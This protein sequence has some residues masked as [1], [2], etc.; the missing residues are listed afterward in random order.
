MSDHK[1]ELF[2]AATSGDLDAVRCL[3]NPDSALNI[4]ATNAADESLLVDVIRA[5]KP[6][7]AHHL[8]DI[9]AAD[10]LAVSRFFRSRRGDGYTLWRRQPILVACGESLCDAVTGLVGDAMRLPRVGCEQ[11]RGLVVLLKPD[12]SNV[13]DGGCL[14]LSACSPA[15]KRSIA[16]IIEMIY[17]ANGGGVLDFRQSKD[18]NLLALSAHHRMP[19]LF[20]RIQPHFGDPI[21][22]D[23][24]MPMLRRLLLIT[25]E[26]GRD[27]NNATMDSLKAL[28]DKLAMFRLDDLYAKENSW[29]LLETPIDLKLPDMFEQM[30]A[31]MVRFRGCPPSDILNELFQK[32]HLLSFDNICYA[33]K[34]NE[35]APVIFD[36][37]LSYTNRPID[38]GPFVQIWI[39][40]EADL[41]A[42]HSK[43]ARWTPL[44][45]IC[46]QH[47]PIS[48]PDQ[49][50]GDLLVR[51]NDTFSI[52]T[53]I[54]LVA[55]LIIDKRLPVLRRWFGE[56][57]NVPTE[58]D[59]DGYSF[60]VDIIRAIGGDDVDMAMA[61][62]LFD[63]C[64]SL[65]DANTMLNFAICCAAHAA[66]HG[67]LRKLLAL[68]QCKDVALDWDH[69][70]NDR[71]PLMAALLNHCA[72]NVQLLL[73]SVSDRAEIKRK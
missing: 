48:I 60:Y 37:S 21:A 46:V 32:S 66:A 67:M 41:L 24:Y 13:V 39:K 18:Y 2:V 70:G 1:N 45:L 20:F 34:L 12:R 62:F 14:W 53:R 61:E 63:S 9:Y 42:M 31:E 56:H 43:R 59:R 68:P 52:R 49:I 11:R 73:D 69:W 6:Q 28:I 55:G 35:G 15:D 16:K 7:V 44:K 64:V 36:E 51:M 29:R 72:D 47:R 50:V 10:L 4:Y 58:L 17:T 65:W 5:E 26:E 33:R 71:S 23:D 25:S 38:F 54:D 3:L 57:P 30:L 19:E 22:W 27:N 8:F 40:Y